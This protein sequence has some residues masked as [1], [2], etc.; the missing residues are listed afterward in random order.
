M[1]L[2]LEDLEGRSIL[3]KAAFVIPWYGENLMGGAERLCRTTAENLRRRGIDVEVLTT[4]SKEFLSDWTNYYEEGLYWINGVPVRRFRVD[5]RDRRLFDEINLK[6][7]N[8]YPI[9]RKEE[10]DFIKHSINSS[11]LCNYISEHASEYIFAFIPYM[12]GTTFFGSQI[13]PERSFLIPCLHDESYAYLDIFKEMFENV[14]GI[15]FLSEPEL[16]LAKKIFNLAKA[17]LRL[18]GA[19]IDTEVD[20][21]GARFIEKYGLKDGFI[22][23]VGRKDRT[24]NTHLLVD[25]FS[26]FSDLRRTKLKLVLNGPGAVAIPDSHKSNVIDLK[27]SSGQ[28]KF[29]AYAAALVT[30]QPSVHESFSMV[31]MESWLCGTPVLVHADCDVTRY[32]CIRSNGGLYFRDF[33]EF[34]QCLD[35]YINNSYARMKMAENGRKYV[36]SNYGWDVI[37]PKY[38]QFLRDFTGEQIFKEPVE[39]V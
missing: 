28:E 33:D 20:F 7:M 16:E 37:I 17:D 18:I 31:I 15:V 34:V 38:L 10:S 5:S 21:N 22:L 9:S 32:H 26:R 13:C 30:C 12:F 3:S 29:D 25:Y 24:K 11:S 1:R 14:R 19:G 8:S 23:Y 27:P 4:C 6:L 39:D 35:F 2:S 36:L